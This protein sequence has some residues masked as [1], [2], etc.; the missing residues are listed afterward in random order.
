MGSSAGEKQLL[1]LVKI[2]L[3]DEWR[4]TL[5]EYDWEGGSI[6]CLYRFMDLRLEVLFSPLREGDMAESP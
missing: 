3:S 1:N 2:N 4:H 5:S 6:K